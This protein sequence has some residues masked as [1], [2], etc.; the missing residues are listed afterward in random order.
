MSRKDVPEIRNAD[1]VSSEVSKSSA[2]D[3]MFWWRGTYSELG[4]PPDHGPFAIS[5]KHLTRLDFSGRTG[6]FISLATLLAVAIPDSSCWE[7]LQGHV[8][9]PVYR[10]LVALSGSGGHLPRMTR[11]GEKRG[12]KPHYH[13]RADHLCGVLSRPARQL[14]IDVPSFVLPDTAV[15]LSGRQDDDAV[16]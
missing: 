5:R 2:G 1:I 9:Y 16:C 15:S 10:N 12:L 4:S 14:F 6:R 7:R 11:D 8:P 3:N 13:V